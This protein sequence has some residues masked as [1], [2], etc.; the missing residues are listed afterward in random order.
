MLQRRIFDSR[1][2][3]PPCAYAVI[4]EDAQFQWLCV[5]GKQDIAHLIVTSRSIDVNRVSSDSHYYQQIHKSLEPNTPILHVALEFGLTKLAKFLL[6]NGAN[7]L[8]LSSGGFTCLHAGIRSRKDQNPRNIETVKLLFEYPEAEALK[9]KPTDDG[10]TPLLLAVLHNNKKMVAALLEYVDPNKCAPSDGLYPIMF[11]A[12]DEI[13]SLL[14][15]AG[16]HDTNSSDAD[17]TKRVLEA[18]DSIR[19]HFP[20]QISPTHHSS[21]EVEVAT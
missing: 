9:E 14:I 15:G 18:S 10:I 8:S 19:S 11:C 6:Y 4:P 2:F 3:C 17:Y 16:A 5:N 7:I 20:T 13:R 12:S 21:K 1:F